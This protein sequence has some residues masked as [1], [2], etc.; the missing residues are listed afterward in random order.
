MKKVRKATIVL[1]S[2]KERVTRKAMMMMI[3]MV[4]K[5]MVVKV[6]AMMVQVTISR[7]EAATSFQSFTGLH[8]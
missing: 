6:R 2:S 1:A 5:A 4:V 8:G 7:K 3:A